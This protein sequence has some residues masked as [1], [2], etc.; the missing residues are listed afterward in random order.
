MSQQIQN[1]IVCI[2]ILYNVAILFNFVVIGLVGTSNINVARFT[3]SSVK[4]L[5]SLFGAIPTEVAF[6]KK[7]GEIGN[8]VACIDI[9]S[10]NNSAFL[11]VLF[12]I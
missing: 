9:S 1:L 7:V 11:R 10:A 3:C 2:F 8:S 4:I 5:S 6:I 12:E